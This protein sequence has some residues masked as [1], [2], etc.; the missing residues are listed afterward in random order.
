MN[1]I[2]PKLGAQVAITGGDNGFA[3]T[4][5]TL[6]DIVEFA[7]FMCQSNAGIPQYLRGNAPDCAAITM[8]ALKWNFDP[9]SVA[10]KSYKVK[11]VLAYEAQLI[12]AVVN[13]RSGIKGRLKYTYDGEGNTLTCT[14]TGILEGEEYAY[15]SPS[16]GS[17]TTKNSPLWKTDPQQQLGYYSARSWARRYTPEVLLGVYD[18]D[19]AEDF[20]GPDKAK[21]VTPAFDPFSDDVYTPPQEPQGGNRTWTGDISADQPHDALTGEILDPNSDDDETPSTSDTGNDSPALPDSE[22]EGDPVPSASSTT[23]RDPEIER[24]IQY[25]KDVLPMAG[26]PDTNGA[27]LSV[28]EKEWAAEIKAMS[29]ANQEKAKGISRSMRAIFNGQADMDAAIQFHA[30][31]LGCTVEDLGGKANG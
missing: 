9:F 13:T 22:E 27:A 29:A 20:R 10:Q 18:R 31:G 15:T 11:D 14:V 12:A 3:V 19:E 16:V 25:A 30:E 24:L 17:I 1:Q 26:D 4:P 23:S 6:S 21:D 7:K 8:Q 5:Q 28:I 2:T